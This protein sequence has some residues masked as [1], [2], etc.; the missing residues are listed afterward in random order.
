MD[1]MAALVPEAEEFVE[2]EG[3]EEWFETTKGGEII[4]CSYQAK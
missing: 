1:S 4:P 2:I 3:Q